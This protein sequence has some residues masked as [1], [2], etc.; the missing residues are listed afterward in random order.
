MNDSTIATR[1]KLFMEK[2][3][4]SSTQFADKC[5]IPRPSFSQF[6]SGRNKKISDAF[7]SMI[8]AAYPSLS[9]MWLMFGEGDMEV[10]SPMADDSEGLFYNGGGSLFGGVNTADVVRSEDEPYYGNRQYEGP[11]ELHSDVL[12]NRIAEL[13]NENKELSEKLRLAVSEKRRV[14]QITVYYDDSTFET[15]KPS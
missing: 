5:G 15:F 7:I 1:L 9:I 13:T 12:N 3:D 14:T 11:R 8:H 2:Y 4:I 10:V 6:L